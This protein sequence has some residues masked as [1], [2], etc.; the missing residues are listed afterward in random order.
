V[1]GEGRVESRTCSRSAATWIREC[2]I[3]FSRSATAL[4]LGEEWFTQL[5]EIYYARE[6]QAYALLDALGCKYRPGQAGLFV[7]AELPEDYE[8]DSFQFS[9]EVMEKC[10]VFLTPGAIF[11][12]EGKRYIRITLC[13]PAELLEKAANAIKERFR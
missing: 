1:L 2:S 10:D 13:C 7:W 8:G 5:N 3:P 9:D 11:G 12:S 4:G 6:K